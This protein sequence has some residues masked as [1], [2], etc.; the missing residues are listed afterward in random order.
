MLEAAPKVETLLKFENDKQRE[1]FHFF[2]ERYFRQELKSQQVQHNKAYSTDVS[3][4]VQ[5]YGDVLAQIKLVF[6]KL[7]ALLISDRNNEG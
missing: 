5:R 3:F 4:L 6:T 1:F 2:A 7:P